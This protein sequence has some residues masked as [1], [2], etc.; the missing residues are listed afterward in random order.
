MSTIST[1]YQEKIQNFFAQKRIAVSGLSRNKDS[2]AGAIYLKLRKNN[3]Q[4]FPLHPEAEALNGDTCYPNLS[5]I[6]GHVDAVFI[7]NSPDVSEKIVDEA[8]QLGIKHIWMH[9]NT[10]MASSVSDA[11]TEK[12]REAGVNV[13]SVGCPMMFLEP[14]GFHSCMRWFIRATGRMK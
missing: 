14:D 9:N 5:A 1:T 10:L 4:V 2:G 11:A 3:Y 12:C 6:P 8:L 7:M 13:I